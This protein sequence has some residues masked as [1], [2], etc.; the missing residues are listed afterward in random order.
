[1]CS[2]ETR[3]FPRTL[4]GVGTLPLAIHRLSVMVLTRSPFAALVRETV[5]PDI[6]TLSFDISPGDYM[7]QYYIVLHALT[8]LLI[9]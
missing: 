4:A 1:M 2:G 9:A 8:W 7:T 5:F 3:N 6:Y